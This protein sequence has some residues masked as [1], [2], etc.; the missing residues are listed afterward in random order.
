MALSRWRLDSSQSG[1]AHLR[2]CYFRGMRLADRIAQCRTPFIVEN[3]KDGSLTHLSGAATFSKNIAGCAT[4]Y[5]L[6]DEL[7][8]LCTALA[9]SK[10]ASTLACADLL[11]V[12]AERVWVEWT[13]APWRNELTVYGFKTPADPANSGRRG[14]F[15][16]STPQGRRGLLRTFWANGESELHVL[17]SSMEAYFDF[18]AREGEDPEVFGGNQ[19][20]SICVSD[21]ALGGA[22]ILRRCFRFRFERSWQDYYE[23][24]Q[25]TSAQATALTHH[26]LGTIAIDIP[27]LLAFFLLLAT[28]PGLPR[29]PL[30]LERLNKARARSGR[31]TLLEQIEVSAPLLPEYKSGGSGGSETS[32]RSRRLHHVRGHLVRRGS[33]L[34]WRVPHLRGSAR[35]GSI[36]TRTVTWQFDPSFSSS[37]ISGNPGPSAA[38]PV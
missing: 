25:L 32:R 36:R 30:M 19:R 24:A 14:V 35:A 26:A 8:R 2:H 7:T 12:P 37:R 20:S 31:A 21:D 3:T 38:A 27:V 16:Q 9:Y 15:I 23:R 18:D 11:H 6:T 1:S 29:R 17:S 4:R 10:G 28:R 33:R 13:E 34:F 22:D 5:V